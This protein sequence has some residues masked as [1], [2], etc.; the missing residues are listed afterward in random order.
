MTRR[1][2]HITDSVW[3]RLKKLAEVKG[4]KVA[5]IV[6]AALYEYLKREEK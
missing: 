6:R 1:N 3:S 4:E 5:V 2:I